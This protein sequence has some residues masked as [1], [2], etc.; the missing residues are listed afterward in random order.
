VRF[1]DKIAVIEN[2]GGRHQNVLSNRVTVRP[3]FFTG[4]AASQ[5]SCLPATSGFPKANNHITIMDF[6][7]SAFQLPAASSDARPEGDG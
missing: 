5:Q 4:L 7:S 3:A 2:T 6:F 1:F